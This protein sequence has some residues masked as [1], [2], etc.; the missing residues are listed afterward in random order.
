MNATIAAIAG[1]VLAMIAITFLNDFG[2]RAVDNAPH[3]RKMP[4][5]GCHLFIMAAVLLALLA[6]FL[7]LIGKGI[8]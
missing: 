6:A 8:L 7:V 3:E 4:L 1:L 5:L 2:E